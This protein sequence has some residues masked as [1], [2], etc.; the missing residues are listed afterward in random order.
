[1]AKT[2]QYYTL[3]KYTWKHVMMVKG[4]IL[5]IG[6]GVNGNKFM[7]TTNVYSPKNKKD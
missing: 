2:L 4:F 6:H 5:D 7:H 3:K 1:M